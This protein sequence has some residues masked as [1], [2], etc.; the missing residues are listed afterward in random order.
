MRAYA[1]AVMILLFLSCTAPALAASDDRYSYITV[2]DVLI[3]L[4]N[5]TAEIG[6]AHV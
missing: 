3:R 1:L 6:R 5:G 4:D 2:E